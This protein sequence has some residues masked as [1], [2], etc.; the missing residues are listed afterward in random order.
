MSAQSN[1]FISACFVQIWTFYDTNLEFYTWK[2]SGEYFE[3]ENM[4]FS[5]Q[6]QTLISTIKR[7]VFGPDEAASARSGH[8]SG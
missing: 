3:Y 1:P 8:T 6:F 7:I 2:G 4:G 5:L